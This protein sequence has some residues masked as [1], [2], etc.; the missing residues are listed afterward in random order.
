VILSRDDD[1]Q[2]FWPLLNP[3]DRGHELSNR[4]TLADDLLARWIVGDLPDETGV[5]ETQTAIEITL[6][7]LLT[8]GSSVNFPTLLGRSVEAGLIANEDREVLATLNRSRVNVKHHAGVI[9]RDEAEA[10]TSLL[11]GALGVLDRLENRI[12]SGDRAHQRRD[13]GGTRPV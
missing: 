10:T 7:Q 8:A 13:G 5:E 4:L 11:H 3:P 9:P 1:G 2:Y 12:E 6:R